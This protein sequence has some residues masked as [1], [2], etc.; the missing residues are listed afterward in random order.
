MRNV[1]GDSRVKDDFHVYDL[2]TWAG[3]VSFMKYEALKQEKFLLEGW[4]TASNE[5]SR[6]FVMFM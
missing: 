3:C 4:D 2:D 5:L 6:I 1:E